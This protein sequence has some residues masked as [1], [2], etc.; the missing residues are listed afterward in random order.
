M[1]MIGNASVCACVSASSH[2]R[3]ALSFSGRASGYYDAL[4]VPDLAFLS[5]IL[6]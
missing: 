5:R 3:N 4:M 1:D 2:L 6:D